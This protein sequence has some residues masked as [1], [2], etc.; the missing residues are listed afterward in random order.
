[1]KQYILGLGF[2]LLL[3]GVANAQSPT[4]CTVKTQSQLLTE[5]QSCADQNLPN[6]C[7]TP[8]NVRD[9]ICSISNIANTGNVS[10][11]TMASTGYLSLTTNPG[12]YTLANSDYGLVISGP[13]QH[14]DGINAACK[15]APA[16]PYSII[17]HFSITTSLSGNDSG[18]GFA[19]RDP[20]SGKFI[21]EY[22]LILPTNGQIVPTMFSIDFDSPTHTPTFAE[23]SAV[24]LAIL[25][26]PFGWQKIVDNGTQIQVFYSYD[27]NGWKPIFNP[28]AYG[29]SY[30]G[31]R[32]PQVCLFASGHG[33]A[34]SITFDKYKETSP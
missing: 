8:V 14:A 5:W 21:T 29:A 25:T 4:S 23:G 3:I 9:I 30:L 19:W 18:G 33:D 2:V 11:P 31:I 10:V 26:Q 13:D 17:A 34:I 7:L 16:S 22:F 28:I 1:M 12:G 27:G 6:K 32:P 15:T 24:Y 20:V